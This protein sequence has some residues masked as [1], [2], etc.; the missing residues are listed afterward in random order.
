MT[1]DS[2]HQTSK[3]VS[4]LPPD[5]VTERFGV[6][7]PPP[8]PRLRRRADRSTWFGDPPRRPLAAGH[9]VLITLAALILGALLNARGLHKTAQI[10]APGW[11]RDVAL[12][13]TGGL[14]AVSGWVLLDRPREWLQDA[15]GRS[16]DDDIDTAIVIPPPHVTEPDSNKGNG[17]AKPASGPPAK[18]VVQPAAQAAGVDG[19]RL[20]GDR[21]RPVARPAGVERAADQGDG[22][23]RAGGNRP[24]AAGR[25]QLVHPHPPGDGQLLTSRC[26]H[27]RLRRQRRSLVHD[28]R[29]ARL[30]RERLLSESGL[31]QGVPP[32]GGRS[33]GHDHPEGR[34]RLLD[35][36]ADHQ[37]RW[38][39]RALPVHQPHRFL[40]GQR[41]A[42]QGVHASTPTTCSRGRTAATPTTC[43]TPTASSS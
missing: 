26:R 35:R 30:R 12:D 40:R 34:R 39:E 17:P 38:A 42:G 36:P 21:P 23:R 24:R 15:A 27:S 14:E 37:R 41:A 5:D 8:R 22:R 25:L 20:A 2:P 18:P 4:T 7:E 1:D 3:T 16:G 6:P 11:Q 10:Q 9:V 19:R 31:G 33:D 28:G 32:A 13:V 29:P 43:P